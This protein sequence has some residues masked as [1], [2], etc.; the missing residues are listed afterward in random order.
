MSFHAI[1][2]S[3]SDEG[4]EE[5]QDNPP[6]V[7]GRTPKEHYASLARF[8]ES[9]EIYMLGAT[10]RRLQ[11]LW[12]FVEPSPPGSGERPPI[13]LALDAACDVEEEMEEFLEEALAKLH[14]ISRKLDRKVDVLSECVLEED[15]W[16]QGGKMFWLD[17]D[18]FKRALA[19]ANIPD[20][21]D[22][23]LHVEQAVGSM[24]PQDFARLEGTFSCRPREGFKLKVLTCIAYLI[25]FG[26]EGT[27]HAFHLLVFI[28]THEWAHEPRPSARRFKPGSRP[29][30]VIWKMFAGVI[31]SGPDKQV[32]FIGNYEAQ[33]FESF[34]G[35]AVPDWQP[36]DYW[37]FCAAY[38]T[39]TRLRR[40]NEHTFRCA[41]GVSDC[42]S[43]MRRDWLRELAVD[44]V[45]AKLKLLA[46]PD[47]PVELM[48]IILDLA[49]QRE[50][51]PNA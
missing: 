28:S 1:E 32:D 25:R 44:E 34:V 17:V 2:Y 7:Q 29:M 12:K 13:V 3:P 47:L 30:G 24:S 48:D 20:A 6:R 23:R 14:G 8:R 15:E 9:Q 22:F 19:Q 31:G 16:Y 10:H 40:M 50:A 27:Y 51:V 42:A 41:C 21:R 37:D 38:R 45:K 49:L 33:W 36:P 46:P 26:V 4:S 43:K 5:D 11:R 35:T 39:M 18:E